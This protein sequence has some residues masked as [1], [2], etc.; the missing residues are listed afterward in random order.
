MHQTFMGYLKLSGTYQHTLTVV[1][2]LTSLLCE[3]IC[4]LIVC[5]DVYDFQI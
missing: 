1:L 3:C 4:N 2:Y 5:N